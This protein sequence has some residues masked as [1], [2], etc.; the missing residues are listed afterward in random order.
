MEEKKKLLRK[1]AKSVFNYETN[2]GNCEIDLVDL[3]DRDINLCNDFC[4]EIEKL[5]LSSKK[6]K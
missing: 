6:I 5:N 1:L 4:L 3:A 2:L